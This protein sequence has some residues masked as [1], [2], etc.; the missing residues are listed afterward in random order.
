MKLTVASAREIILNDNAVM[1]HED[2][3]VM[4]TYFSF[5]AKEQAKG[6]MEYHEQIQPLVINFK[7]IATWECCCFDGGIDTGCSCAEMMQKMAKE[8]LEAYKNLVLGEN[9]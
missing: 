1:Q 8:A 5:E 4:V 9:K 7:Q 2:G 3:T 6:F